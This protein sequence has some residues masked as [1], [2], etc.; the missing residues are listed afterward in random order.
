MNPLQT[1]VCAE[2]TDHMAECKYVCGYSLVR[3]VKLYV[4]QYESCYFKK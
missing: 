3:V 2:C 1:Y 4:Y